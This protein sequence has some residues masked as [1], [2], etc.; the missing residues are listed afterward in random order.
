MSALD[1][2]EQDEEYEAFRDGLLALFSNID[3]PHQLREALEERGYED[4]LEHVDLSR[5]EYEHRLEILQALAENI[6]DRNPELV[7]ELRE[8]LDTDQGK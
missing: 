3:D 7:D 4:A 6:Q 8:E 2:M 5:D 1:K